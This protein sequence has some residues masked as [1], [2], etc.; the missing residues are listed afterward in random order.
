MSDPTHPPQANE[1]ATGARPASARTPRVRTDRVVRPI[2]RPLKRPIA[3][4]LGLAPLLVLGIAW[5]L[6]TR[7]AIEERVLTY[8][9]LPSPGEVFSS[10]K[11][12]WYE[13]ALMRSIVR[14]LQRV[15]L[16]F[17]IGGGSAF[18]LAVLMGAFGVARAMLSPFAVIGGYVPL[19]ALVPLTLAWWG[20]DET[21]K[22]GFLTIAAFV[23]VWPLMLRAFEDVND[24]YL[25]TA[26]TLGATRWQLIRKVF[27]P[28]AAADLY[29]AM[30]LSFGVGWA[31]VILAEMIAAE[32]GVGYLIYQAQRRNHPD[33]VYMLL[34]VIIV[35]AVLTDKVLAWGERLL[36]PY[37]FAR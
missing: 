16:A 5:W 13:S 35:M 1:A 29:H 33:Q 21:Q 3:L 27:V 18:V 30:R 24:V 28:V 12:L 31:Y 26:Y 10:V 2:R 9:I 34:I 37:R 23:Y 20:I 19:P 4:L 7:G 6:L 25:Q 22:V 14:S 36:F 8:Q 15:F 17:V 32:R 11:T